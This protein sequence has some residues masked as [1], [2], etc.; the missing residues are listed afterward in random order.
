LP[1]YFRKLWKD[2]LDHPAEQIIECR[3]RER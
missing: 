3:E 2:L 1:A